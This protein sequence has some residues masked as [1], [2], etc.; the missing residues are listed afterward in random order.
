MSKHKYVV[1]FH[2]INEPAWNMDLIGVADDIDAAA[3]IVFDDFD[4]DNNGN[5]YM[6]LCANTDLELGN[7]IIYF[8]TNLN[9]IPVKEDNGNIDWNKLD[10][11]YIFSREVRE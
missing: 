7:G 4:D 9:A 3:H 2:A 6:C 11:Y 8:V 5:K 1:M 10:R